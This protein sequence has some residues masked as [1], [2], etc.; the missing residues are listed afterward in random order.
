MYYNKLITLNLYKINRY[1]LNYNKYKWKKKTAKVKYLY[2]DQQTQLIIS[3]YL[4]IN[5]FI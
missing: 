4:V 1:V 2:P 3:S 5:I